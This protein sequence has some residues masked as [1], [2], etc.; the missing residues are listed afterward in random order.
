[1]DRKMTRSCPSVGLRLVLV[2]A[3]GVMFVACGSSSATR[4]TS[5]SLSP[6]AS[7]IA[8]VDASSTS[9]DLRSFRIALDWTPNVDFLG[10][11]A[12]IKNGYFTAQGIRPVIIPYSGTAGETLLS[13]GKTDLA[14]TYPP[15]IPAYRASGLKYRAVAGLT[16][17]NTI[18]L[19]VLQS[20]PYTS[21]AQLSGKLYGGFGVPSDPPIIKAIFKKVGVA[22]PTYHEV[23]LNGTAYQALAAKRVAYSTMFGGID[24]VT[25][26]LQGAKLRLFPIRNY[27]GAAASFPD[28]SLAATDTEIDNDPSLLRKGLAALS[29]G[30]IFAAQHPAQAEQDLIEENKTALEHSQNI[31][32]ATGNKTAPTFLNAAGQWGSLSIASFSGITQLMAEGGLFKGTTPPPAS[33]DYTDS[34]LPQG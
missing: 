3:L 17:L 25:A 28:D 31:I 7:S 14:F 27:L 13:A 12:A 34:L 6:S 33:D 18:E 2:V 16:Q 19:A 4:T 21:P 8:S 26:E 23:V 30:Y 11:Y 22:R 20:S 9:S 15:N 1:M 24:D 29:Q 10:V 5:T 32:V